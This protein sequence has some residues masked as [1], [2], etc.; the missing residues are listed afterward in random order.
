MLCNLRKLYL[1]EWSRSGLT[2]E[3]KHWLRECRLSFNLQDLRRASLCLDLLRLVSICRDHDRPLDSSYRG[4]LGDFTL[5]R[6][7]PSK[8]KYVLLLPINKYVNV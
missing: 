6:H 2:K 1:Q 7:V 5:L 3:I 8:Y 4:C